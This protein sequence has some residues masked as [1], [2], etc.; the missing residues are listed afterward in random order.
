MR[1]NLLAAFLCERIVVEKDY[2]A[3]KSI[4]EAVKNDDPELWTLANPAFPPILILNT[5]LCRENWEPITITMTMPAYV[6]ELEYP[7]KEQKIV[8]TEYGLHV[9]RTLA[10]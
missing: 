6:R 8:N 9:T 2:V 4:L 3:A 5:S 7:I 1:G 10:P